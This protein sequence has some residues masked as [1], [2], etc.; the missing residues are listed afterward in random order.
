MCLSPVSASHTIVLLLLS[1]AT[2]EAMEMS[3]V[4][5]TVPRTVHRAELL[6]ADIYLSTMH[7]PAE[8]PPNVVGHATGGRC[9]LIY[10][11]P[12]PQVLDTE[13]LHTDHRGVISVM[14]ER[15]VWYVLFCKKGR[16][17]K[18]YCRFWIISDWLLYLRM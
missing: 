15:G 18:M 3:D 16:A 11:Y 14:F 6:A 8:L 7:L 1:Q 9:A 2:S 12:H 17:E 4:V 5:F 13:G 10:T